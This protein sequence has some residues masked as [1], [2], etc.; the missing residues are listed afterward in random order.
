MSRP[1]PQHQHPHRLIQQPLSDLTDKLRQGELKIT[2]PR[3]AILDVLRKHSSPLTI[4][5]I[6]TSLGKLDCDLATIYRNMHTLERMG[7]VRR[8]D[9]GDGAARFELSPEDSD[10]HHHHLVCS[11]CARIVELDDCFL[12]EFQDQLAHR[13][14]F[15]QIS[16][17]MEFFGICPNCQAP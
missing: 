9:F 13:H 10:A 17:R 8:Y 16:H 12:N 1:C 2:A 15:T 4:K 3:Q 6:H 7:L 11:R 5:E 14:G